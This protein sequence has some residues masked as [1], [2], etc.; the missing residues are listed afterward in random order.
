MKKLIHVD[1]DTPIIG[2]KIDPRFHETRSRRLQFLMQPS[3]YRKI[4]GLATA[5]DTSVNDVIHTLLE[6]SIMEVL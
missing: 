5:T 6:K 2:Y 4:K 3:L 1:K